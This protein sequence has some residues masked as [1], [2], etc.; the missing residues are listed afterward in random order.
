MLNYRVNTRKFNKTSVG[1]VIEKISFTDFYNLVDDS[2]L[3]VDYDGSKLGKI[4][5]MCECAD[6]DKMVLLIL[7]IPYI[8]ITELLM[9]ITKTFIRLIM[10]FKQLA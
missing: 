10:N 1:L 9:R 4:M 6:I 7:L 2:D 5:I 8:L 3:T